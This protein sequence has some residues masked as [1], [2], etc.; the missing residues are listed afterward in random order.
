MQFQMAPHICFNLNYFCAVSHGTQTILH[1][2]TT[3]RMNP[4]S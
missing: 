1:T 4:C 2:L 3:Y